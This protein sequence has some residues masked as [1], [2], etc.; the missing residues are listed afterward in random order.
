MK[1]YFTEASPP[2]RT[3][4][5]LADLLHIKIE[6]VTTSP[7]KGETSSPSFIKMNPQHVVPT[8]VDDDGYII[9]ES[10]AIAKYLVGKYASNDN[11]YPTDFYKRLEVDKILD[12]DLGT[13]FR[14]STDYFVTVL[15]T[16]KFD[17]SKKPKVDDAMNVLNT[18]LER[19]QFGFVAGENMTIA[20]IS[21]LTIVSSLEVTGYDF[22][23]FTKIPAWLKK[24]KNL[25]PTY[26]TSGQAGEIAFKRM[27]DEYTH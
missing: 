26:E 20:D 13:V 6:L 11:L 8:L 15:L 24:V 16:G 3:I 2:C 14:R 22:S 7:K 27:F 17:P 19:N 23:N 21:L 18:I 5:L 1:L 9:W 10:R 12:F 25:I 4:V